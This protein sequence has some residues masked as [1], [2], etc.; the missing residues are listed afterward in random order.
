VNHALR[1]RLLDAERDKARLESV[2]DAAPIGYC[3]LD[4]AGT[5]LE[6][7]AEAAK[8]LSPDG[9]PCAGTLLAN[10]LVHADRAA[11]N[12]CL[13][14][15]TRADPKGSASVQVKVGEGAIVLR[16]HLAPL[17]PSELGDCARWVATLEDVTERHAMREREARFWQ[18][19]AH[20]QDVYYETDADGRVLCLSSG[21]DL[22]WHRSGSDASHRDWFH[23][24]HADDLVHV[25]D[26]RR[27]LLKGDPFDEQYRI[28]RPDGEIRWV[29]DRAF[30]ID[31]PEPHVV[32]VARD[33]TDD[34]ELEE[35]L[36]QAQKLE[37]IG[38]LA[39][40]VAH[41]FGNLLQG[42]MGCLNIALGETTTPERSRD[43]TR[44]ALVAVRGGATLVG[45]L[46]RFG[47]KDRVRPRP[48][49]IDAAIA[50]CSK[51]LQRLLGDH[52]Q[53][54][55]ET[56]AP[57]STMLA[58][59][60][61][62]E[63]ILMNLAANAR[64]AMPGGGR[65]VIRTEEVVDAGSSPAHPLS[66]VRLEVRDVG[67]GMDA[68]TRARV[69]EPFFTTKEAG[70]GTGLGLSAVRAVTRALG[71][72]VTVETELGCGTAFIFHFPSVVAQPATPRRTAP[73]M[74]FA[75]R[76]L[77]VEDD[78][79]V[80][81]GVRR[82]LEELGFD[83]VEAGDAAEAME[84]ADGCAL[85]VTDVVLP[86]VSGSKIRNMLHDKYPEMK[87]LFISAHPGRYLAE[88]GLLEAGAVV[89][90]K[91]F[92]VQDLAF[93][94]SQLYQGPPG[95]QRRWLADSREPAAAP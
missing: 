78:W 48:I 73:D 58:D 81:I 15:V 66:F 57:C 32:G 41:D 43:Y 45:Q 39:S 79:R 26:A 69:F 95:A 23:A 62:I 80:R 59:P 74:R 21:Y 86:E 3:L 40:S 85:L 35:E 10:A 76:A 55:I 16:V 30:L 91:P 28:V 70:K 36:R 87:A 4:D 42:V 20:V 54:C 27:L 75:G 31:G 25:T 2:L 60:V 89:L 44:Q 17:P 77:L 12:Q 5:I 68:E 72:Q 8:K 93:R 49:G 83:V 67:C 1:Q 84:R 18:I 65:L 47:R 14:D 51:L 13:S 94:L 11:F 71:G 34:R 61:Q 33:I 63:Q 22:V 52:I 6:L 29:H 9:A 38:T 90:Q 50:S 64:D 24:L 46:M 82:Y 53:L 88:H 19:A 37:A 92:E 7:N 56:R